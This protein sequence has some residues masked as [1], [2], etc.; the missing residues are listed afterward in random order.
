MSRLIAR[1]PAE[2]LTPLDA[3]GTTLIELPMEPITAISPF[4]GQEKAVNAALKPLGLRFPKPGQSLARG[5]ARIL[6]TGQDQAFLIGV[7]PPE[8]PGAALADQSDGWA[9][10]RLTG[11]LAEAA[12]ARLVPLDLRTGAFPLDATARSLLN[13][14]PLSVTRTG[15]DSFDLMVFRS[16]ATTAVHELD[17]AMRSVAARQDGG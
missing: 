15:T 10:L 2:G 6:W 8:I 7:A 3:D 4:A 5:K 17:V 14:M 9:R 16:M 1:A 11:A 12:L 13:H